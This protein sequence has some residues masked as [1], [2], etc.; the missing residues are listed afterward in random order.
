MGSDAAVM[1]TGSTAGLVPAIDPTVLRDVARAFKL[2]GVQSFRASVV[3]VDSMAFESKW[4]ISEFGEIIDGDADS[5][6]ENSF[7]GASAAVVQLADADAERTV[8]QKLSPRLWGFAWRIDDSRVVVA[9][10]YFHERRDALID[11][12]IALVRLVCGIGIHSGRSNGRDGQSLALALAMAWPQTERRASRKPAPASAWLPRLSLALVV[13]G[14]LFSGWLAAVALPQARD[15]SLAQQSELSRQR[16]MASNTLVSSLSTAIASGDYGD[17]QHVLSSFG[18]LGYF[19]GAVVTNANQRIVSLSGR[20]E[21]LR[22]GDPLP[23]DVARTAQTLDLALGSQRY[24]QL[25]I[26]NA[27]GPSANLANGMAVLRFAAWSAFAAAAAAAALLSWR[28]WRRAPKR[29]A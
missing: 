21:R 8:T 24:G 12:D 7:V 5:S 14:A 4:S 29:A 2:V 22:I 27:P 19:T 26:V 6:L 3:E 20:T 17:A 15:A 18:T 9:E 23:A 10:A 11:F 1:P 16:A 25:L 13:A 28:M